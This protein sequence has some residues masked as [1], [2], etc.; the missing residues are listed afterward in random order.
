M[1]GGSYPFTGRQ[2]LT[3]WQFL[4]A[5]SKRSP[6]Q[7]MLLGKV[8]NRIE[9]LLRQEE[10]EG[11]QVFAKLAPTFALAFR[12]GKPLLGDDGKQAKYLEYDPKRM[13]ARV[14]ELRIDTLERAALLAH[15]V[16][17][18]EGDEKD[19]TRPPATAEITGSV[20]RIASWIGM[21]SE[22]EA[23]LIAAYPVSGYEGA[24]DEVDPIEETDA[25]ENPE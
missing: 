4:A 24:I 9:R 19:K 12:D 18:I 10:Q 2:F 20:L 13:T 5:Q 22:L 7:R 17:Q 25:A 15:M 6:A 8:R 21:E 11:L 3:L 1:S 23:R 14:G 16:D